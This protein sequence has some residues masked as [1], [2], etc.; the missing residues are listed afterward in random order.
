MDL[1]RP[2]PLLCELNLH[3]HP[4][5]AGWMNNLKESKSME[6][7]DEKIEITLEWIIHKNFTL[8]LTIM[9]SKMKFK[10]KAPEMKGLL[11]HAG[12]LPKFLHFLYSLF[13]PSAPGQAHSE[14]GQ[15]N[16]LAYY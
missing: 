15:L 2:V 16:G 8:T 4:Y 5:G 1:G 13:L 3:G 14:T 6:K 11:I 7:L 12:Y 9:Y 10:Q